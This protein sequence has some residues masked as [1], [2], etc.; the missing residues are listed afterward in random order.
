MEPR[1]DLG[2][3]GHSA[4]PDKLMLSSKETPQD[5]LRLVPGEGC[6]RQEGDGNGETLRLQKGTQGI[7]RDTD[8]TALQVAPGTATVSKHLQ[9]PGN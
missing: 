3:G 8:M 1:P 9:C 2:L 6:Q 7:R 5:W 4:T